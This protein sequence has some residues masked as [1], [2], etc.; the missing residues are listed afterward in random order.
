MALA[1]EPVIVDEIAV[2]S[3]RV[4]WTADTTV[5]GALLDGGGATTLATGLDNANGIA[6]DSTGV[7][8]TSWASQA[9]DRGTVTRIPLDGG[10]PVTLTTGFWVNPIALSHGAIYGTG[11]M[12]LQVPGAGAFLV[13]APVG[14]GP[15]T[16]LAPASVANSNYLY[17]P[18]V[19]VDATSVYW[20]WSGDP[21]PV[22]KI[23][24]AGGASTTLAM[25]NRITGIAADGAS[26]YW[27]NGG[28]DTVM[29]VPSGGGSATAIA[30]GLNG[31]GGIATDGQYVYVTSGRL[32]GSVLKIA[33]DG[34]SIATLAT[35]QVGASAIAVDATSV[36]W[37]ASSTG[38]GATGAVVPA[39]PLHVMKLT[40][41]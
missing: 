36:Y 9:D 4:Y 40:P 15:A 14:G 3:T 37:A 8:F 34:S 21:A 32:C 1:A 27:N 22:M 30:T 6:V 29:K 38:S 28:D 19:A 17:T 26:V 33:V 16:K 5:T 31:L 2:D 25:G 7:Y 23:A 24:L 11:N 39:L 13:S 20:A 35:G 12:D 18:G 41:K 10:A